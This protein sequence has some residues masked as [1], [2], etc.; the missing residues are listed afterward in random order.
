MKKQGTKNSKP[1]DRSHATQFR[2]MKDWDNPAHR[3]E[4]LADFV[5]ELNA[6]TPTKVEEFVKSPAK[7]KT[8]FAECGPFYEEGKTNPI[9]PPWSPRSKIKKIPKTTK[10][11]VF[12]NGNVADRKK[13]EKQ[14]I[15]IVNP[16]QLKDE[17]LGVAQA[18]RCTY[19]PYVS[20]KSGGAPY[21][22]ARRRSK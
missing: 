19:S 4:A 14:V 2:K 7:T 3:Q 6:M 1:T 16:D 17:N 21:S 12:R 18:W 8:K 11:C 20:R 15:L 22:K 9:Y 5:G 13:R 10:F